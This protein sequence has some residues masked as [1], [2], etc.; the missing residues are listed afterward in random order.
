MIVLNRTDARVL[1]HLRDNGPESP[2]QIGLALDFN[3][4]HPAAHV[5]RPLRRLLALNL[6]RKETKNK[7]VVEYRCIK[8]LPPLVLT[9]D[10][11]KIAIPK[12]QI[13][14]IEEHPVNV[15]AALIS[16]VLQPIHNDNRKITSLLLKLDGVRRA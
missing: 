6:I 3:K 14:D 7:R 11:D 5:T 4:D 9:D 8:L 15:P 1:F 13:R 2:S 12:S 10:M 16:K